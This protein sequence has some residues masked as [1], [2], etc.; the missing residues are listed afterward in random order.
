M[1]TGQLECETFDSDQ[2]DD[3]HHRL[4]INPT[5]AEA[6]GQLPAQQPVVEKTAIES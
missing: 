1:L 5:A 3:R 4:T 6:T 2:I